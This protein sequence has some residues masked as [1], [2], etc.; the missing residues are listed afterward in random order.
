MALLE[1]TGHGKALELTDDRRRRLRA[2]VKAL[3]G[4]RDGAE[5]LAML[6]A[7]WLL[8]PNDWWRRTF[9]GS[10]LLGKLL[11]PRNVD[12]RALDVP[13]GWAWDGSYTAAPP[14]RPAARSRG[15]PSFA[16][17]MDVLAQVLAEMNEEETA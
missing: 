13:D 15:Q 12:E 10:A 17:S 4:E 11:Q 2:C 6:W 1:G 16:E 5:R 9:A 14:L 7:W 3:D 8:G